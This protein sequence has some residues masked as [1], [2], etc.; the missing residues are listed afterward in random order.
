M[1]TRFVLACA[2]IL[3]SALATGTAIAQGS[4]AGGIVVERAWARATP[5]GAATGG[6]YLTVINT[7]RDADRLV[8][9]TTAAAARAEVHEMSMADGIMRM[10]P[11]AGGLEIAPGA[12]VTLA[13][14]GA[15]LMLIALTGP[16]VA[17]ATIEATLTFAAA[18]DVAVTFPVVPIGAAPPAE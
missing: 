11:L 5:P 2:A 1:H 3:A 15:H 18:G 12:S 9:A 10:R 7:G 8:G 16:L 6:A 4:A 14:G 13:P 17:G